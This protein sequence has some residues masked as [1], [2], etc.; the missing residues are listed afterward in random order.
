MNESK[1]IIVFGPPAAGKGTLAAY[2]ETKYGFKHLS[3]GNILRTEFYDNPKYKK[4]KE[5]L[6]AGYFASDDLAKKIVEDFLDNNDI[7]KGVVFDG[8]PRDF[9]QVDALKE[10]LSSRN[11]ALDL[12]IYIDVSEKDIE[13][14]ICGRY[15]CREC[16]AI[17][18]KDFKNTKVKGVCDFCESKDL[19]ERKEDSLEALEERMSQYYDRTNPV[20]EYYDDKG[21]IVTVQSKGAPEDVQQQVDALLN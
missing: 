17:Y 16:G 1:N 19:Y 5:D 8:F 2:L 11:M 21:I 3:T 13:D 12:V 15:S 4:L 18:H 7:S 10:I 20:I 9:K 6:E 14:R